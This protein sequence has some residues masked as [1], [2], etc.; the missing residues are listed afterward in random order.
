[1]FAKNYF[2]IH[3]CDYTRDG[4]KAFILLSTGNDGMSWK[5]SFEQGLET[6]KGS[7]FLLTA[8]TTLILL[9]KLFVSGSAAIGVGVAFFVF[10]SLGLLA[11]GVSAA[12]S[13]VR[14]A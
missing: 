6:Y 14:F 3:L 10:G 2:C 4:R 7:L 1:M 11:A 9:A 13:I 8:A 5:A 12:Y